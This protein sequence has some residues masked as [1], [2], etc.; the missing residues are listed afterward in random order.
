[1]VETQTRTP[2][3]RMSDEQLRFIAADP[4]QEWNRRKFAEMILLNREQSNPAAFAATST[5]VQQ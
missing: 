4:T 5:E 1:M 2:L 3:W